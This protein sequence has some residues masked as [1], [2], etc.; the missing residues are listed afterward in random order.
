L[1]LFPSHIV[2]ALFL[3]S[4]VLLDRITATD[5]LDASAK[6]LGYKNYVDGYCF[7]LVDV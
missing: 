1:G 7:Q 3:N 2:E 6:R 4:C 5:E